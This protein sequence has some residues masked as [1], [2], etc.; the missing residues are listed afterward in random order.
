MEISCVS[1]FISSISKTRA[2]NFQSCHLDHKNTKQLSE[3]KIKNPQNSTCISCSNGLIDSE[4]PSWRSYVP[5]EANPVVFVASLSYKVIRIS[6][7][8]NLNWFKRLGRGQW[9]VNNTGTQSFYKHIFHWL[10]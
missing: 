3:T 8:E 5:L 6:M 1:S 2:Y 4:V 10:V 7:N 9:T